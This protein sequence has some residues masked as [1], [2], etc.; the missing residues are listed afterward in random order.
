MV[1]F[2]FFHS[3]Y[4]GRESKCWITPSFFLGLRCRSLT[5]LNAPGFLRF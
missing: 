1:S 3:L 2:M 5:R 4:S